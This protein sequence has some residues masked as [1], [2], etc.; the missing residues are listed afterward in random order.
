MRGLGYLATFGPFFHIPG[1]SFSAFRGSLGFGTNFP[2]QS[3]CI[4]PDPI[5]TG[6]IDG[7]SPGSVS[8]KSGSRVDSN[9]G[10]AAGLGFASGVVGRI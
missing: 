5:R 3:S 1:C 10:A 8:D 4:S 2:I 7:I 9:A 6:S